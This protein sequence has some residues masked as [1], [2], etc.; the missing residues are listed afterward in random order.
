MT[1]R[2][3]LPNEAQAV[4]DLYHSVIDGMSASPYK[5]K[6]QKGIYP[7]IEDISTAINNEELYIAISDDVIIS[8]SVI[9][10]HKPEAGYE[11]ACWELD[12][13]NYSVV[14]LLAVSP[15]QQRSGVAFSLLEAIRDAARENG[16]EAIRL[17]TLPYNTPAQK[18]YENFGFQ[19]RGEVELYYSVTGNTA[20][21]MY[22]YLF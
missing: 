1:V 11:G 15:R 4:L 18:L 2:K 21:R 3:A 17:D 22:E 10:R 16:S 14:H 12:T 8:G 7:V 20:Y 9:L 13:Q 6:W 5:P 19:Y